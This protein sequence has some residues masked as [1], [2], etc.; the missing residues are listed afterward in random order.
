MSTDGVA[1]I[2]RMNFGDSVC[3]HVA[4]GVGVTGKRVKQ[5]RG[6]GG[7]QVGAAG[8]WRAKDLVG[9]ALFSRSTCH[10]PRPGGDGERERRVGGGRKKKPTD[11][12]IIFTTFL[13]SVLSGRLGSGSDTGSIGVCW[14]ASS[15]ACIN[16]GQ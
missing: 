1:E 13:H 10:L 11:R 16:G 7:T 5:T 6:A 3:G 8:G 12:F 14:Y 2:Y 4:V 15:G 9:A